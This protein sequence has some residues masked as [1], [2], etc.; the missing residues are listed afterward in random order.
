MKWFRDQL[1]MNAHK[2]DFPIHAPY[3]TLTEAQ[4]RLLWLGNEH[5]EGLNSFFEMLDSQRHKIQY[6]VLKARFMGQA[7]CPECHRPYELD[8]TLRNKLER[9]LKLVT[10]IRESE[11]LLGDAVI[12]VNVAGGS[13]KIPY[14]MMLTRLNTVISLD[15]GDS[16]TDFHLRV[17]PS[18]AETFR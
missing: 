4:K 1:V 7:V 5:F 12:S 18:G 2:F 13:V 15:L 9:M 11:D 16:K 6:R 10:V 8:E 3:H 14:A 17:E